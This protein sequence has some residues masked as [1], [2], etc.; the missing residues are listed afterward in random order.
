MEDIIG[1]LIIHQED[2]HHG[3]DLQIGFCVFG[4]IHAERF[5]Y[6]AGDGS[7]NTSGG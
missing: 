6:I 2:I 5:R 7:L 3:H 1:D 4:F